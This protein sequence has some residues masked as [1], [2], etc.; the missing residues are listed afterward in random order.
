[1]AAFNLIEV[2]GP[3]QCANVFIAPKQNS[4]QVPDIP[5]CTRCSLFKCRLVSQTAVQPGTAHA[6]REILR[7]GGDSAQLCFCDV[8]QQLVGTF[9]TAQQHFPDAVLLG[10]LANADRQ[11]LLNPAHSHQLEEGDR[12]LGFTRQGKLHY[13]TV[14]GRQRVFQKCSRI[15]QFVSIDANGRLM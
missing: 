7:A 3:S 4:Y 6:F 12:L 5:R 14:V 2:P 9:Q 10:L 15:W 13:V 11:L 1:M 8:D